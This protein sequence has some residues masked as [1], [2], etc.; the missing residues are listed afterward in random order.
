MKNKQTILIVDD[1]QAQRL[2]LSGYL[3][4]KSYNV[5]EASSGTEA[6]KIAENNIL[7]IVLSDFKMPDMTGIELLIK[8]KERNPE[9]SVVIITAFGTIENAVKAMKEGAYDYLTKPVNL[10]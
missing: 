10:D 7:D 4:Q 9:T 1:E 3:K 8:L 5:L 2:V 6:L